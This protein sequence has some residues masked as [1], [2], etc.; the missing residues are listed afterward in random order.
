M[1]AVEGV[2]GER[3]EDVPE[4]LD[5]V[6]GEAVGLHPVPER[7]VLLVEDLLLL[8]AHRAAQQV[9]GAERVA[10]ELLRD[11]HDLLL[12][13]DQPV[14]VAQDLLERLGQLGVDRH[15]RLAAGLAVGVVVVGVGAHRARPVEREHRRDGLEAVRLHRAEQGPHRA[16]VELE[17]PERVA[18]RQQRVGRGV[19]RHDVE[20]LEHDGLAAVVADVLEAVVEHR[21]VAQ[22]Q[23]VH[24]QQAERL[25]G[26]HVELGDDRAVLL[27]A[28]D[29]DDVEQRLAAQDDAG[30]VDAPLALEALEPERGVDDGLGVGVGVVQRPE[31]ARL[32]VALVGRVEDA[33]ERDVLAHDRRRHRLGDLVAGRERVAEHAGGVLDGLLGLDR[34]VGDDLRDPL[35]AVLLGGV[36]DHVAAPA[37]V[38]VEVDVG[39]RDALGVEE[40][41]EQQLVLDRVELGDL[42]RVRDERAG[43]RPAPRADPDAAVLGVAD[44]VGGD[45][46]VAGEA[47]RQDDVDLVVGLPGV[48]LRHPG[49]EALAQ[50]RV[51]LLAQPGVLGVA[52]RHRHPRHEVGALGERRLAALGDEQ[53]VV[54]GLRELR[55]QRAH[56]LRALEVEVL[57]VELEAARV[58]HRLAG[59][60]A[61]QHLVGAGV[62][63]A[64]VV[65]VVGRDERDRQVLREPD[66]VLLGPALDLDAV[67]HELAVE[68]VRAEDVAELPG[69]ALGLLVLAHAQVGLDLAGRAARRADHVDGVLGEQLLVHAR[70]VVVALEAR[71][72][73]TAGTARAC[74]RVLVES[75]VMWV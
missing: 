54:A 66:E 20:L 74:P 59:L 16:A 26:T 48:A 65:Q 55:P 28:L 42:E 30:R 57:R 62:L 7:D 70:L 29:R 14:G 34:A 75:I 47:H 15:D 31:L 68:V 25:A 12:V 32:G 61:Q 21:E 38:E 39:H 67:V 73:T 51:D 46:E 35:L 6:V 27:A 72:A 17:H 53:R 64:R 49:R 4:R 41:L 33:L 10:G 56:L 22:P 9:G 23:E 71:P 13:H 50:P 1:G 58:G 5:R 18:A 8:L 24:L 69:R 36:A 43:G 3:D 44:E 11:R 40:A 19:G 63:G 52:G 37:L 2:V 45:E 60:H